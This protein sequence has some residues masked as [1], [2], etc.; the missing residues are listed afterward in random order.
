MPGESCW[1][2]QGTINGLML[3]LG[4]IDE[5]LTLLNTQFA[6]LVGLVYGFL[7]FM[8]LPIFASVERFNFRYVD[9]AHDLGAND[10]RA[11]LRV[12]LP[13]TM[14]GVL[15]GCALVFIPSVGAFVTAGF[16]GRHQGADDRQSD[17]QAIRRLGQYAAGFG[18]C[19]S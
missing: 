4:L 19:P 10:A 1:A 17:Q 13:L 2:R 9:A 15:A 8:V 7:P 11:F 5:P 16:A 3:S 18:H 14:P 6:V 12:V